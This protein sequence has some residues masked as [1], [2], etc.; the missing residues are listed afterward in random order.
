MKLTGETVEGFVEGLLAKNF[1]ERVGTPQFHREIW[2]LCCS[3]HRFVAIAAPRSFAKSTA[4]THS[5]T[6][7]SVLF[8]ERSFVIL[9]SD[10]ETQAVMFLQ[11]IKK[12]LEDNEDLV[13]LFGLKRDSLG[14]TKFIKDTE[15]DIIVP[16]ADG[17]KFRI[18][19][20]GSEQKVR[21]LKWGNQRPDLIICDDLE[22]DEIVLN[23]DRRDK[24][25]RWFMGA[26]LPVRSDTGIVRVVGTI[27]HMD[28]LLEGLM[29]EAQLARMR[30]HHL[31][32]KEPLKDSSKIKL[33]WLSVK[34]R[35][36][37]SGYRHLLWEEKRNE[38][39]LRAIRDDYIN[40]GL[41]EVY[42]QEY[43]NVPIDES[44]ALFRKS[45]FLTLRD[46][47]FQ[48]NVNYYITVDL[49]ISHEDRADYSVF[50]V[51]GVDSDGMLSIRNI[52]RDRL[53]AREIV[54]LLLH[55]Q[56]QYNPIAVGVEE[57]MIQKSILPFLRESMIRSGTYLNLFPLKPSLDKVTRCRSIQARMRAGGVRFNKEAE[58]YPDLE[59][60]CLR[61][62]TDKHDDQVDTLSYL[63][64][65]LDKLQEAATPLEI[66]RELIDDELR[67]HG[68]TRTGSEGRSNT[69][70][71]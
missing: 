40:Q 3:P 60:E 68:L 32:V 17:T 48:K 18:V 43:L 25:K 22:N 45:D 70:G 38:V 7:A 41:P 12:E 4:V 55:L 50:T 63:G 8:R 58:W 30:K 9:V 62:P 5:Y 1:A 11:D 46:E 42:S 19:A 13:N 16:F 53:D 51:G 71:Y 39:D 28:S 69:T 57:G 6:L 52:I 49:A 59:S 44:F 26:L 21:G 20:K 33:P 56:R 47:D 67:E 54:D 37:D 15:S 10:T 34:Y 61:F 27:L 36:H 66:E 35:A 23:K 2:D 64:L 14:K 24:F 65:M 31:L 29:P